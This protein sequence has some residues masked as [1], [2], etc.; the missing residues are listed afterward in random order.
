MMDR[1]GKNILE[2]DLFGLSPCY[3]FER[4]EMASFWGSF[5]HHLL[6]PSPCCGHTEM[7]PC[8]KDA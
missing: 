8:L 5:E 3:E 2:L 6:D 4:A 1:T 7:A